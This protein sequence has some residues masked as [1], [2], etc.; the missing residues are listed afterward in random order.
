MLYFLL[1]FATAT[2]AKITNSL[3]SCKFQAFPQTECGQM[4]DLMSK[5][6]LCL[7]DVGQPQEVGTGIKEG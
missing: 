5:A 3:L 1:A 6:P 2:L 4:S 7:P